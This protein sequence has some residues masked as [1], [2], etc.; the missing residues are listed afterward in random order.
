M[1]DQDVVLTTTHDPDAV[2]AHLQSDLFDSSA[3]PHILVKPFRFSQ[4][5]ALIRPSESRLN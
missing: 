1:P 4:L 2:R 3:A 5:L